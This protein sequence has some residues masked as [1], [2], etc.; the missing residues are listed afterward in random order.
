ALISHD[1]RILIVTI[2]DGAIREIGKSLEGEA[3]GLAWSP[4][5][6]Y[7][8]WRS[9]MATGEAMIGQIRCWD[10]QGMGEPFELT[11]GAFDDSCPVFTA[12]GKYLAMLSART[13]DPNYDGQTFDLSFG[14]TQR[15]WLVPLSA[16]EAS[17]FG[18]SSQGWRISEVQDAKAKVNAETSNGEADETV[19]CHVAADGFEER[20]V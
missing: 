5:S 10:E 20:M 11:R 4:D 12:D 6:R 19:I 14:H 7:V 18:P 15:P 16:T 3:N 8:V 1:G 2:A 17:P 13:F 9:P